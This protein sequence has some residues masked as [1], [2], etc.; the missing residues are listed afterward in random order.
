MP[1]SEVPKNAEEAYEQYEYLVYSIVN[2]FKGYWDVLSKEDMESIGWEAVMKCMQGGFDASKSKFSNYVFNAA[3]NN[4]TSALR[5]ELANRFPGS[6]SEYGKY[7]RRVMY[8]ESEYV[9]YRSPDMVPRT[10]ADFLYDKYD[11]EGDCPEDMEARIDLQNL[12]EDMRKRCRRKAT[13]KWHR[14]ALTLMLKGESSPD[15]AKTLGTTRQ[16]VHLA[17]QRL[18]D[19]AKE[20]RKQKTE[21]ARTLGNRKR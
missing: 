11:L 7:G 5:K 12:I 21:K 3:R 19:R 10:I 6:M 16:A 9:R 14:R 20:D 8:S 15:I 1:L 13:P 17:M 18:R 4:I 2:R